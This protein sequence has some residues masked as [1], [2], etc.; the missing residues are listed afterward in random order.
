MRSFKALGDFD[1]QARE[2]VITDP[3]TP[4]P[5]IN[6]I[7]NGEYAGVVSQTGGGFSWYLDPNQHRINRWA[8]ANYLNDRP[9]RYIYIR[10]PETK[11]V[12][13]GTYAPVNLGERY[14]CRHGL[15]YSKIKNRYNG[16]QTTTTFF[17]PEKERMEIWA[18]EVKNTTR[19]PR[20]VE[21]YPFLEWHLGVWETELVVRNLTVLMNE[22]YFNDRLQAIWVSKFPLGNKPW[23]F[24]AYFA[25]SLPV[26]GYD[27]DYESFIGPAG[28]YAHPAALAG[29]G[30]TNSRVRGGNMVGAL[31]HTLTIPAGETKYFTVLMGLAEQEDEA[32]ATIAKYREPAAAEEAFRQTKRMWRSLMDRVMIDTPDADLNNFVNASLKYQVA[33]N[34]HW[35]RSA[36]YYHEGHGEFGFRNTAQDAW[37]FLPLDSDYAR[38]RMILLAKHQRNTGQPMAGWSYVTGTNEGK[39]P[40]DFPVWLPLLVSAYVKE[41]GDFKIL[42]K[43]I[44]YYDGGSDTLYQHV[45]KA[46]QFLQ[47]RAKSERG[48]PLMGTQ[49]WNDA[50]DR[51]GIGGK[52][53]SVWLGMGLCLGLKML[54]ELAQQLGDQPTVEECRQRYDAMRSLINQYAW[55]GDRYVYAFNDKGE[56]VGSP[57]NVEG[58]CQL[59]SQTWA[60]LAGIPDAEQLPKVLHHID[61]TLATPYGPVLFA[62][63]YTKYNADLG[64]ITAFAPGTKENAAIFIHGGAF[65]IMMDYSLGRAEEAYKTMRQ[66]IPNAS[67]KDIDIYKAEPYVFPEYVVGPGNPR[68]G[69]GAFTWLTGS[70][71]WFF[72]AVIQKMLGVQPSF[73]GLRIDPCIPA[74]WPEA[75]IS[76]RFRGARYD[77]RILNPDH[78]SRGVRE[79]KV[80]GELLKGDVLPIFRD[81]SVHSIEVIL[82]VG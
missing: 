44:P 25:S 74:A 9:G 3:H 76:R 41:T 73:D 70:A 2:F 67:D 75:R 54:E 32:L 31:K 8:P 61:H 29:K 55:A 33:M 71:D 40:A 21:V 13:S 72:I 35:G 60:I 64:R 79:I 48:L 34:N 39:A 49:D 1:Q 17:V 78:V 58:N 12:S 59:N 50:F 57:V 4:R 43:V 65:K 19:S 37:G 6:Y 69:E 18:V 5:W 45:C 47:D 16:I 11:E 23:P 81:H 7:S 66:I 53:E 42:E 14:E 68:Y 62:P 51:T 24:H 27:V 46:M 15:G 82:G 10:D 77:I 22:G 26:E 80:D 30:C 20:T 38:E 63:P 52:G 28:D 36:T 56:P